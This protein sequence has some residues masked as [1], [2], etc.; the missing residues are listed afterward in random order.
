MKDVIFDLDKTL[1]FSEKRVL[2]NEISNSVRLSDG[3]TPSERNYIL[4][5]SLSILERISQ[6][7]RI[8]IATARSFKDLSRI[9]YSKLHINGYFILENGGFVLEEDKESENSHRIIIKYKFSFLNELKNSIENL[10]YTL[11]KRFDYKTGL[12]YIIPTDTDEDYI[13]SITQIKKITTMD[14][15]FS[16]FKKRILINPNEVSKDKTLE[17]LISQSFIS[18]QYIA[19]GD[20]SIDFDMLRKSSLGISYTNSKIYSKLKD[21]LNIKIVH[22]SGLTATRKMLEYLDDILKNGNTKN[23]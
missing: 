18:E 1:I 12:I 14:L 22:G 17:R 9:D 23:N 7:A 19:L 10:G 21:K 5:D 6:K 4:L 15:N 20:S 8:S 13:K 16:K 11:D 2:D 3:E